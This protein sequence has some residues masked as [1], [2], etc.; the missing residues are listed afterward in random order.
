MKSSAMAATAIVG[1]LVSGVGR[2]R[3]GYPPRATRLC[4]SWR[5][6][7]TIGDMAACS[8]PIFQTSVGKDGIA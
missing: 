6:I 2:E 5:F 8:G 4:A 7:T 3:D 1:V